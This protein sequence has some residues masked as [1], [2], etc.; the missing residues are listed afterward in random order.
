MRFFLDTEFNEDGE[1]IELISIALVSDYVESG[2]SN[3]EAFTF[4][5]I[6]SEFDPQCCNEWVRANVLPQLDPHQ[7]R[8]SRSEIAATLSSFVSSFREPYEFWAYF[9]DYDWIVLC[10][11]FGTMMDLP[12]KFPKFCLDLKQTMHLS[13]IERSVLP[14]RDDAGVHD[15]LQDAIWNRDVYHWLQQRSLIGPRG[16]VTLAPDPPAPPEPVPL[17]LWCPMCHGR[18]LDVGIWATKPHHT[19]SCQHCGLTWRPAIGP[20]AGVQFLPGFKNEEP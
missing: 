18:H 1:T 17:L 13:G 9:A 11:L 4:Y 16:P 3:G 8:Q 6:S 20:T 15:A 19:H 10:Q 12:E 7:V 5:A 14:E 2:P